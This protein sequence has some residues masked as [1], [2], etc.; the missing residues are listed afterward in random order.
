VTTETGGGSGGGGDS[1]LGRLRKE[2]EGLKRKLHSAEREWNE[3]R[4]FI[5]VW[6][7]Y[8][9]LLTFVNV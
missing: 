5:K 6:W 8:A 4:Y 3:V 2:V 7:R 1:V 9:T